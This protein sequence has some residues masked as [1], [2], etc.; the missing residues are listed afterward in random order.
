MFSEAMKTFIS[1][2]S[3]LPGIGRKSSER[4]AYFLIMHGGDLPERLSVSI[5]NLRKNTLVCGICGNFS[6]FNPCMICTDPSRDRTIL[7]IVE[8]PADI[9]YLEST[10]IYRG[11]YHSLGG[12]LSPLNGITPDDLNLKS[13]AGRLGEGSFREIIF[14]TSATTE[15]DATVLF[16][17]D[18]LKDSKV[19]FSH[20][21]RGIPVGMSIQY[22][23]NK[24][25]SEALKGRDK[26]ID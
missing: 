11:L 12:V 13:L 4:I 21:A 3:E 20:L 19:E 18:L 8:N 23:G 24:S 17:K 5:D 7:C 26:L 16:I 9:Y 2:F 25:L 14:A 22:A 10:N 1:V 15:G 6:D